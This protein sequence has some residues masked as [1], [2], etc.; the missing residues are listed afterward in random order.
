MPK[1]NNV[2]YEDCIPIDG[3]ELITASQVV[4]VSELNNGKKNLKRPAINYKNTINDHLQDIPHVYSTCNEQLDKLKGEYR[5][6]ID[7]KGAFKQIP[8]TPGFSQK[9]LAI[10]TPRGYAVP[11]RMQFGIKTAPAIWNSNM[12]KLIHGQDGRGPVKAACMVDDVCVT[13]DSPQEHL[14]IYM[15]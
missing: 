7:L 8:V 15:N 2:L 9:I 1:S 6:C 12:Q 11:T 5:T 13:G 4:L 3:R 14:R 10:V